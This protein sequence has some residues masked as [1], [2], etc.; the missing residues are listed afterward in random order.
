MRGV[1]V[2]VADIGL[3]VCTVAHIA[4]VFDGPDRIA[5]PLDRFA[6]NESDRKI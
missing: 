3:E 6:E 2:G 5:A 4:K 1:G